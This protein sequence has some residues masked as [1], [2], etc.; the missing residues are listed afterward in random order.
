MRFRLVVNVV[1]KVV[2]KV[3]TFTMNEIYFASKLLL[4]LLLQG[5]DPENSFFVE[6]MPR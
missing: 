6:R 3:E 2:T 4:L 5:F 1:T